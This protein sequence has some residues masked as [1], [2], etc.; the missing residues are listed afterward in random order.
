MNQTS[1]KDC[2]D[3]LLAAYGM[4]LEKERLNMPIPTDLQTLTPM[5]RQYFTLKA[6]AGDSI[7]FFRM[8][9]FYEIFGDDAVG[10]AKK[11]QIVLTSRERG[12]KEKI[13]FCGVPHHSAT[14]YWRKLL[15]MG[16]S[17]AVAEQVQDPKEAKGLVERKIIKTL[18]PGCVDDLELLSS[19]EQKEVVSLQIGEGGDSWHA[20]KF[21]LS[22]GKLSARKFSSIKEAVSYIERVQPAEVWIRKSI[23]AVLKTELSAR[24]VSDTFWQWVE[25][26][27]F[28]LGAEEKNTYLAHLDSKSQKTFKDDKDLLG[29]YA[30]TLAKLGRLGF[31]NVLFSR[32]DSN[33]QTL[34]AELGETCLRDLEVFETTMRKDRKSS[35]F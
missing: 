30:A 17:I 4:C 1:S 10:A 19:D 8:G 3:F 15:A 12:D 7:L 31:E 25:E 22:L 6:E 21:E 24:T 5:L 32:L 16:H 11:L 34:R 20:L 29:L 14:N 27:L 18:T 33:A 23:F 35:L 9:D 13:P 2:L 26:E 28:S